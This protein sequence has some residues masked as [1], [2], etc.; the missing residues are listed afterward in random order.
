MRLADEMTEIEEIET[1]EYGLNNGQLRIYRDTSQVRIEAVAPEE[2][3]I[4][5]QCKSLE[6]AM[7]LAH[8]TKKSL[9]D[10]IEMGYDEKIVMEINDEDYDFHDNDPE[11]LSRF[12]DIG[13]DRGFKA[14]SN[15]K[16]SRQV[17][18]VEAFMQLDKYGEGV[19]SLYRI[20]KSGGTMLE[21]EE[22]PDCHSWLLFRC[23]FHMLSMAITLQTNWWQYRMLELFLHGPFLTMLWL[24]TILDTQWLKVASPILVNL[25]TI[26]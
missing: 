1:D 16:M 15:Q 12:N 20:V 3:L 21:C 6:S 25:S 11:I 2:F 22:V 10:L 8:R 9:S 18:V 5:P 26:A 19:C 17:T 4:E 23:L 14:N 13:A 7:F 24:L